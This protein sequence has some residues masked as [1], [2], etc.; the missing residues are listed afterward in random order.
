L[1][2]AV[3]DGHLKHGG[4]IINAQGCSDAEQGRS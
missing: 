3:L 2:E 1:P 4:E